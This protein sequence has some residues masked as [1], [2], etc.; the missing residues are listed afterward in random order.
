MVDRRSASSPPASPRRST[1]L[2]PGLN[3]GVGENPFKRER[4]VGGGGVEQQA[5]AARVTPLQRGKSSTLDIGPVCFRFS[6]LRFSDNQ[7][8]EISELSGE[9]AV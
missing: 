1:R 4:G 8:S 2:V 3:S 6:G 9:S 5:P 7:D